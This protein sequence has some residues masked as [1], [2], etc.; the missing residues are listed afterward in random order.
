MKLYHG[1]KKGN[2]D[3]IKNVGLTSGSLATD[4]PV[5]LLYGG[6]LDAE[7][8]EFCIPDEELKNNFKSAC[9]CNPGMECMQYTLL[10][11]KT[12]HPD[13]IVKKLSESDNEFKAAYQLVESS[14][15]AKNPK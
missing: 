11:G 4:I 12:I 14:L 13:R 8:I 10:E 3:K 9:R 5:C 7:I 1:T 2:Y 15:G 6:L